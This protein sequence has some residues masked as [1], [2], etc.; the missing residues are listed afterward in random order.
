[1]NK[2]DSSRALLIL[3]LICTAYLLIPFHRMTPSIMSAAI[4]AETGM[5]PV[6]IGFLSSI[7]FLTFGI[8]QMVG[9]LLVDSYGPRKILPCFLLAATAGTALFA[10]S[11]SAPGLLLGRAI[12][13]FGTSVIFVSGLKLF[14]AWFPPTVY[15][16]LNGLLLG[17]GGLGLVIGSGGMGYLCDGLGWRTSHLIVALIT[18]CFAL[19]LA[20][21]VRD[22]PGH[23]SRPTPAGT[24]TAQPAVPVHRRLVLLPVQPAQCFRRAVGRP[25]PAG[26]PP[27]GYGHH[28][29]RAEHAGHRHPPR[30]A[31]QCLA[32]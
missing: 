8:M 6:M 18:F 1:M 15:A 24:H 5:G 23:A 28:G 11:P 21:I 29:Q 19:A 26:H 4:M 16:R 9:G 31:G 17:M 25:V 14:N 3:A 13:G 20:W 32:V 22:T 27:S 12:I 7:L 30:F 2:A 10:L